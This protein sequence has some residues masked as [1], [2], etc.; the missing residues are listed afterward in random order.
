MQG[1]S[2]EPK[3]NES[4]PVGVDLLADTIADLKL[5]LN[6][7]EQEF[8]C[9]DLKITGVQ[10]EKN[11]NLMRIIKTISVKLG[12]EIKERDV[13]HVERVGSARRNPVASS[14][15][16]LGSNSANLMTSR[17]R[18][19]AVRFARRATHDQWLHASRVPGCSA[20]QTTIDTFSIAPG[21]RE[22]A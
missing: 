2:L 13:V 18:S 7:R 10:E 9:N 12:V 4:G 16:T 3:F 1:T 20:P 14:D 17:P 6:E 11:E 21:K 22:C 19:I 8:L 15:G 5:Q